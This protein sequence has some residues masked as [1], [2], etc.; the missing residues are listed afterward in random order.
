MNYSPTKVALLTS[1]STKDITDSLDR[2]NETCEVVSVDT[3]YTEGYFV[4]TVLY[5]ELI[6]N[7]RGRV[8]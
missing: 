1:P 8:V 2:I 3:K 5:R 6:T 4:V 7:D